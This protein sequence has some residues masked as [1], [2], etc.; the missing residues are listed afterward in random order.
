MVINTASSC[1]YAKTAVCGMSL[2]ETLVAVVVLAIGLL[3]LANLNTQALCQVHNAYLF[4]VAANQTLA[5]AE[6]LQI[7]AEGAG[8]E[9]ARW[10]RENQG[11]LPEG[12]GQLLGNVLTLH[13][14]D[15]PRV[16]LLA[17]TAQALNLRLAS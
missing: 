15:R 1:F 6:Y 9:I 2:V 5:M 4:T 13:W 3:A 16:L 7:N 10:N 14:L 8:A 17:T 12:R 11:L